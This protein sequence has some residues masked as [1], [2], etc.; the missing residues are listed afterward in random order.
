MSAMRHQ[1]LLFERELVSGRVL[2]R[3]VAPFSAAYVPVVQLLLCFLAAAV[4]VRLGGQMVN[5]REF[6]ALPRIERAGAI[7]LAL[8]TL[9]LHELG[10]A[11]AARCR[12]V[13]I[14]GLALCLARPAIPALFVSL[15]GVNQLSLAGRLQIVLGG[16]YAQM[17]AATAMLAAGT[18]LH[19]Q[20]LILSALATLLLATAELIPIA[21]SDGQRLL[22]DVHR[23][24]HQSPR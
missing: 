17:L 2:T 12:G 6:L 22:D 10:H 8:C 3:L 16:V 11:A 5:I 24:R 19:A 23:S 15:D 14:L 18:Y 7:L 4:F 9:P 1:D 21:G 20:W 13:P